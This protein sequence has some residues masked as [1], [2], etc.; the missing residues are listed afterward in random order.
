[1]H[2][3]KKTDPIWKY[4]AYTPKLVPEEG[5]VVD[6]A[7]GLAEENDMLVG[8]DFM[9]SANDGSYQVV[10]TCIHESFNLHGWSSKFAHVEH[11]FRCVCN[12]DLCNHGA[13]FGGFF[14]NDQEDK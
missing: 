14:S 5:F 13:L 11:S 3:V 1:G 10:D 2:D 7:Y 6:A 12:T 4:C 8:Y 9:F